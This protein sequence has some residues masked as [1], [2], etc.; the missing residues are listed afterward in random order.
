M[1][2]EFNLLISDKDTLTEV[3]Q[4]TLQENKALNKE[5]VE[6][7]LLKLHEILGKDDVNCIRVYRRGASDAVRHE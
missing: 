6:S 3:H 4:W 7:I 2:R 1:T 5:I